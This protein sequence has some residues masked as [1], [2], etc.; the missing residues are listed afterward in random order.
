[1]VLNHGDL[2]LLRPVCN[3]CIKPTSN[4]IQPSKSSSTE[5]MRNWRDLQCL[6]MFRQEVHG[7]ATLLW[8]HGQGGSFQPA[9]C[10]QNVRQRV[11]SVI[12][13]CAAGKARTPA[14]LFSICASEDFWDILFPNV[15]ALGW[16]L[17]AWSPP[18]NILK[19]GTKMLRYQDLILWSSHI[20]L[21][22]YYMLIMSHNADEFSK[23]CR[24]ALVNMCPAQ[25]SLAPVTIASCPLPHF[26]THPKIRS[27]MSSIPWEDK[28]SIAFWR[29]TDR[30]AVNWDRSS[31]NISEYLR[32]AD[33][34][35]KAA[36]SR[37]Q[38]ACRCCRG[39]RCIG[40]LDECVPR[41]S[42]CGTC[43]RALPGPWPN[44]I[45]L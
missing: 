37:I 27:G 32:I 26:A 12:F 7:Q 9:E 33:R 2:P 1:M 42:K 15:S 8:P 40:V 3:L 10:L 39:G 23:V 11:L 6:A 18:W 30:G 45:E 38:I 25:F 14:P 28:S 34:I 36:K 17:L 16:A 19:L 44:F 5:T 20:L 35:A 13:T 24:P 43:T 29:G 31:V 4:I 22:M 41:P 21:Y